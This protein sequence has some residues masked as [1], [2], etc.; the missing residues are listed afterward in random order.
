MSVV[1]SGALRLHD[2]VPGLIT[3]GQTAAIHRFRR[4]LQMESAPDVPMVP[5]E[6]FERQMLQQQPFTTRRA[7]GCFIGDDL[8]ATFGV[9]AGDP[10]A[11][12][13]DARR[14]LASADGNVL[15]AFRGRGIA[16]RSLR[17]LC[18]LVRESGATIISFNTADEDGHRFL[19]SM[20]AELKCEGIDNELDV[21]AVDW[22]LVDRWIAEGRTRSPGWT[23]EVFERR[24]P[25]AM[26]EEV[27][28]VYTQTANDQPFDNLEV[29]RVTFT[30][31]T[32]RDREARL[33]LSN[34]DVH[35]FL[36]RSPEGAIASHT[37]VRFTPGRPEVI[38]QGNTGTLQQHRGR[39]L[40]KWVKAESLRY[41]RR[42]YP[43]T[44]SIVTG[45]TSRNGAMLAIN[46][47]LGFRQV[48]RVG[49]YQIDLR[50]LEKAIADSGA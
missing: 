48:R 21:T 44:K 5:D 30:A 8:V 10:A 16:R 31:A 7:F 24:V 6:V 19:T 39:G 47:A 11:P 32:L 1:D 12:D 20:G 13:Y 23:V 46:T 36:A 17:R 26:L 33:Q 22:A 45:N 9:V 38:E 15:R 14:Y 28:R 18:E 35:T 41:I 49:M 34:G 4:R 43:G 40:A 50:G 42:R 37:A 2:F 3:P 25:D 29:G 27:S